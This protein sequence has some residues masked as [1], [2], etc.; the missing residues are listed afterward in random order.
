MPANFN[1][2]VGARVIDAR[3]A[4]SGKI[5]SI[6][7]SVGDQVKKGDL[8]ASLDRK[9]LQAELDTEL[10]DYEKVRADFEIFGQRNP[11]PT[12]I[13]D[14]YLKKEKQASLDVSVKSVELAKARLDLSRLISP[15]D[16]IIIDDNDIVPG[17]NITPASSS[18]KII[19]ASSYYFEF[20]VNQLN[21]HDFVKQ[22]AVSV[23]LVGVPGTIK[24][25]TLPVMSDGKKFTVRV[26]IPPGE[27]VF[28][29]MKG[30]AKV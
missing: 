17:I 13:I 14:K 4:L 12:E 8:I 16:G 9:V 3:F 19:D 5:A 21:V 24:G 15:V 7:K 22:R 2:Q 10:A 1:G 26:N 20:E 6:N 30:K 29:G 28:I 25:K 18:L 23:N 27:Y 11:N